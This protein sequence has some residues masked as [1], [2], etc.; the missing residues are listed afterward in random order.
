MEIR[1][2]KAQ[3][4]PGIIKLLQQVGSVH[5]QGRPDLFR[6]N[7]QKYSASQ[8][9]GML[10]KSDILPLSLILLSTAIGSMIGKSISGKIKSG[11]M[12]KYAYVFIG[13]YG[14]YLLV[15]ELIKYI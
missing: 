4:V 1:F 8:V 15:S 13:L 3:D 11:T 12:Q 14:I 9:L 7:A 6:S 5:H 10:D 2:A